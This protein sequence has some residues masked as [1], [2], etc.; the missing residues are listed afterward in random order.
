M[1]DDLKNLFSRTWASFVTELERRDPEDQVAGL[2]SAMRREMVEARA[3][4]PV[5]ERNLAAA[6]A[7][8]SRERKRL[9]DTLRRG[10]MAERIGDAETVR[11]AKEFEERH[12]KRVAVLEEKARA[13]KAEWELRQSESTEMMRKYKEAEA[14]RF[15][16]L[17]E[18]RRRGAHARINSA[19]GRGPE[20]PTDDF[21]RMER[22]IDEHATYAEALDD[23]D[24]DLGGAPP[25]PPPPR[26]GDVDDQLAE[27]KRRMGM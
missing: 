23:L 16:L 4:L 18:I 26:M 6:E 15:A 14:N 7:E 1:L 17:G 27:L 11:V 25:P 8:L 9:D 12:R 19:M 24:A 22:K 3:E 13:A 2:L 10:A 20:P 21:D 5:L